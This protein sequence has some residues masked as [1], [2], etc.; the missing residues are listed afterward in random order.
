V[1]LNNPTPNVFANLTPE[2]N[3]GVN[4][5]NQTAPKQFCN[6]KTPGTTGRCQDEYAGFIQTTLQFGNNTI[7]QL[8]QIN[9]S[10]QTVT[11]QRLDSY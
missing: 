8:I 2:P 9:S 10:A 11:K 7:N 4:S 5:I 1:E 6:Q 3:V